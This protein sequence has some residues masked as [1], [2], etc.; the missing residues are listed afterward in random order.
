M[1]R[2][3]F[4]GHRLMTSG[5]VDDAQTAMTETNV[6]VDEDSIVVGSAVRDDVAHRFQ[7]GPRNHST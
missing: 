3:I 4:V 7:D 6:S 2:V 5:D 1:E